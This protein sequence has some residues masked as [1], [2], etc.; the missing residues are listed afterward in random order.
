VAAA[1]VF[2]ASAVVVL[3]VAAG[4][5]LGIGPLEGAFIVGLAILLFGRAIPRF[6]LGR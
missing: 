3:L 6:I 2:M 1:K 4:R 5:M